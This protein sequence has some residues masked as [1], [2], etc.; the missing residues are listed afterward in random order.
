MTTAIYKFILNFYDYVNLFF[1]F[2]FLLTAI[3]LFYTPTD[4]LKKV[5]W[6]VMVGPT[7]AKLNRAFIHSSYEV[8]AL[9][10]ERFYVSTEYV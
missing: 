7:G 1:Y 8:H 9:L 3:L 6:R 4:T 10:K 2:I 5:G